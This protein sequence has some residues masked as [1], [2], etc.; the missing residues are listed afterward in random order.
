MRNPTFVES[1]FLKEIN[2][3]M[4]EKEKT[5]NVMPILSY[6]HNLSPSKKIQLVDFEELSLVEQKPLTPNTCIS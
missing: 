4:G 3:G 2:Q 5:A 1:T 6:C